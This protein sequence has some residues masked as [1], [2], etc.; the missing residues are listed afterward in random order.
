MK[1]ETLTKK[2]AIVLL[3]G[4]SVMSLPNC[5]SKADDSFTSSYSSEEAP[6]PGYK[7]GLTCRDCSGTGVYDHDIYPYV[8]KGG[9]CAG[10][11]GKGYTW[12]KIDDAIAIESYPTPRTSEVETGTLTQPVI[13]TQDSVTSIHRASGSVTDVSTADVDTA[14]NNLNVDSSDNMTEQH[15]FSGSVGKL[16][17]S[18]NL[19]LKNTGVVRGSYFYNKRPGAVYNLQGIVSDDGILE[20]TELTGNE[21]TAKCHLKL[22]DGCYEG[23]MNNTDGRNFIMRMCD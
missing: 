5:S 21:E 15:F 8:K 6:P 16:S 11:M 19:V 9:R 7:R 14:N 17:A 12:T 3:L 23:V 4:V 18:F 10:C 22:H 20:L 2:L 13:N 1:L